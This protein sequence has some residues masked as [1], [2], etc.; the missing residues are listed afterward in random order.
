MP[1]LT[2]GFIA[3][4]VSLVFIANVIRLIVTMKTKKHESLQQEKIREE[5]RKEREEQRE[6]QR[7]LLLYLKKLELERSSRSVASNKL[8]ARKELRKLRKN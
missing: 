6:E 5:Q 2:P 4:F 1:A 3:T 8:N 7:E